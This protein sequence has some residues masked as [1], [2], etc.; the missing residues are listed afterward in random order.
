MLVEF[1]I[2]MLYRIYINA[3]QEKEKEEK[4]DIWK[5]VM[6]T[7]F[8]SCE[9]MLYV[10]LIFEIIHQTCKMKSINR[11]LC[12]NSDRT[13]YGQTHKDLFESTDW[14]PPKANRKT[15]HDDREENHKFGR[16][17]DDLVT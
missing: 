1:E 11:R 4:P 5:F 16:S 17:C 9:V 3:F 15:I 6:V 12:T 13:E 8:I 10:I 7:Y 2:I 14:S